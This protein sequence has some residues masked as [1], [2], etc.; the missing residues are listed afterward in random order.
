MGI[1]S[2]VV[3]KILLLDSGYAYSLVGFLAFAEAAIFVGFVLPGETA[4]ILGG[5]LAYRHSVSLTV[6]I[7]IVIAAAVLGDT[8]GYE[9]GRRY[10]RRILQLPV[11]AKHEE[12]LEIGWRRL[13][14]RGGKAVFLGR[15]TAFLRA[16]M[17]GLA[18][19]AGMPYRTIIKRNAAGGII[20]GGGFTLLGFAAG[21]SYTKIEGYA[22]RAGQVVLVLVVV[23]VV[24]WY[25]RHRRA[26]GIRD[27]E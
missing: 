27:P 7:L 12:A 2:N 1:V 5:V 23:L 8:V 3:D 19:T 25:V 20:W 17:P 13:R 21:A 4:V 16:A 15:F 22:G 11:F 14:E 24:I 18:G 10:G 9:V 26:V 6:M